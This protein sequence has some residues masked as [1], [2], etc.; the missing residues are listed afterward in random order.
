MEYKIKTPDGEII[1]IEECLK[2][3]EKKFELI[4]IP[5]KIKKT[6]P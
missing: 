4:N 3:L 2:L 1:T 5:K 6:S